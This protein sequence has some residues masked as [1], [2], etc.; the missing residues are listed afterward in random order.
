MHDTYTNVC[1]MYTNVHTYTHATHEHKPVCVHLHNEKFLCRVAPPMHKHGCHTVPVPY[2]T[3]IYTSSHN[4]VCTHKLQTYL[5]MSTN[6]DLYRY[7]CVYTNTDMCCSTYL[8]IHE[9]SCMHKSINPLLSRSVMFDSDPMDC[10]PPGS[11]VHGDSPGKNTGVGCHA[12][13]QG[14]SQ[15]RD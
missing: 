14:S 11:S 13:F 15:P 9:V 5:L 2:S 8:S 6:S 3:H 10:S 7:M 12:F 1:T 4:H